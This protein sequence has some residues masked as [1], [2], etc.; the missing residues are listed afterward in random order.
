[1]N[2]LRHWFWP[3]CTL[4][5]AFVYS[6]QVHAWT[7]P[8]K[9]G[10]EFTWRRLHLEHVGSNNMNEAQFNDIVDH[11]TKVYAPIAKQHGAE[12][13]ATKDWSD[14]TI[15]AYAEQ[16]GKT[17]EVHFFGGLAR[18]PEI[19]P[20]GFAMVVCHELGHHFGGYAF[21]DE[22]WA[23]AEGEAD[24][25]A[26]QACA[27]EIWGR[28]FR[29]NAMHLKR[30][31]A[32]APTKCDQVWKEPN[33]LAL[34]NRVA[35]AGLS[36]AKLLHAAGGGSASTAPNPG[37]TDPRQVPKTQIEH[38]EA[39]CRLDTYIAGAACA[40]AFDA[41]V[42]PGRNSAQGQR[43]PAAEAEAAKYSCMKQSG[44]SIG[45][46]PRCWFKSLNDKSEVPAYR[47]W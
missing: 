18:Q 16:R 32:Q 5:L 43:S 4:V 40:A 13:V 14:N 8:R 1:M 20:D 29:S 23:A 22:D 17:W 24:Y 26:T 27:R 35:D 10:D 25:W 7:L 19:T 47:Y 45:L 38:P 3:V 15:N 28:A 9:Q 37:K 11:I 44:Y 39:Q 46:R 21:Y 42:I 33:A 2:G 30:N 12:L 6:G 34:C 41:R 31:F 36:L